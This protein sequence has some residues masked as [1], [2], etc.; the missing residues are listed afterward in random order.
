MDFRVVGM[1]TS[2]AR[3][4]FLDCTCSELYKWD[5]LCAGIWQLTLVCSVVDN[6]VY[7]DTSTTATMRSMY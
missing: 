2:S 6:V 5:Y 4:N 7:M 1:S 3:I